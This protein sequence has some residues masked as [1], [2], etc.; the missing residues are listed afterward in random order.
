[1]WKNY[2]SF[3]RLNCFILFAIISNENK[4]KTKV[5]NILTPEFSPILLVSESA[6]QQPST[7]QIF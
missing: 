3:I 1:M 6:P 2:G 7:E 5:Q 4:N